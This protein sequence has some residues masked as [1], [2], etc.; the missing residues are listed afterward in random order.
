[1]KP[2]LTAKS[3]INLNNVIMNINSLKIGDL[4]VR[5]KG[6]FSTHFIVYVG[7]LERIRQGIGERPVDIYID[8]YQNFR[9]PIQLLF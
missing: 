7:I 4:I 8:V 9:T 5:Q 6:P 1:M 3:G 2:S